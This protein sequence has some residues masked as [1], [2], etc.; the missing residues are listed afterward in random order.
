MRVLITGPAL[1]DPGGVAGYYRNLLPVLENLPGISSVRYVEIGKT[2]AKMRIAHIYMDQRRV[3]E[4]VIDFD[5]SV[6]LVNPSLNIKSFIRDGLWVRRLTKQGRSV[7]VFFH[8]WELPF[9]AKI[10]SYGQSR[11]YLLFGQARE[12]IVLAEDFRR[13]LKKWLP[14]VEVELGTTTVEEDLFNIKRIEIDKFLINRPV[15]LLFMSR[16]V[17]GKGA[18]LAIEAVQL[19]AEKGVNVLLTIAGDGPDFQ[20]LRNLIDSLGVSDR[21]VLAGYLRGTQKQEALSNHDIFVF[22]SI[23]G[24][25]MPTVVL[26]A[27]AAGMAVVTTPVGGIADFFDPSRMGRLIENASAKMI[28]MQVSSIICSPCQLESISIF[29]RSYAYDHF[30]PEVVAKRIQAILAKVAMSV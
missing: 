23:Y 4:A 22:P 16:L 11:F 3:S 29:N 12:F 27:M 2:A 8:G 24:E 28:A 25:G 17:P 6:I 19:L 13:K 30:H 5:P 14:E 18:D 9:S 20:T 7:A 15:K 26:E 21:V 10:D 1:D